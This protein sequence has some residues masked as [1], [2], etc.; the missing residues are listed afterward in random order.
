VPRFAANLSYLFPERAFLD[1]FEAA[2]RCGFGAVEFHFPYAWEKE[3]VVQAAQGAGVEVVLFNLPAGDWEAGERGIACHPDRMLEFQTGTVNAAEYALALGCTRLNC[4]AGIAPVDVG[5]ETAR[6]T[7]I[8]NLRFAADELERLGIRLLLEPINTR[9]VPGFFVSRTAQ[10]V[11]LIDAV[12]ADNLYL[13]YDIYHAQV[14]EGDLARTIEANLAR[15]A[16]MQI[17]DNPGR[18]EPG[19]GEINFDFL[20]RH[21]DQLGYDGWI[22]CEYRPAGSTEAGLEWIKRLPE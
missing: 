18:H 20:F 5:R 8:R 17:A 3:S 16:H 10:A 13:Q 21:I 15:I 2:V 11:E 14:M 4:L 6:A 19:T 22:G 1:R 9:D 7:L 12:G